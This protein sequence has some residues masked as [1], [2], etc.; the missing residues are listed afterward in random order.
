M[1]PAA[2]SGALRLLPDRQACGPTVQ[3]LCTLF[4]LSSLLFVTLIKMTS[5]WGDNKAELVMCLN[6]VSRTRIKKQKQKKPSVEVVC[7]CKA[8][9]GEAEIR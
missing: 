6:F 7:A 2:K 1:W 3:P 9:A 5:G 8:G 4:F